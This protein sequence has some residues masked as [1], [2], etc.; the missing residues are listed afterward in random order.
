MALRDL[1][2]G[3]FG[4]LLLLIF[5]VAPLLILRVS[6]IS[7]G[8]RWYPLFIFLAGSYFA[9]VLAFAGFL[10]WRYFEGK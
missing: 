2:F 6:R 3:L 9:I 4:I 1:F 5:G 7:R 10:V 8:N